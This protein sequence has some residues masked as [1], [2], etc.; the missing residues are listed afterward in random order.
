VIRKPCVAG[1]FYPSDREA[2]EGEVSSYVRSEEE[3]IPALGL[4]SPHAGYMYSGGVAGVTF[5]SVEL[6]ERFI[7]LCPNH[8]G[9]GENLS[10][11]T[12][13]AWETPLGSTPIDSEIAGE[14]L[15]GYHRLK[16]DPSAHA[17]EHSLEVQL[18]FLQ[19]LKGPEEFSF[20]PLCVGERRYEILEEVGEV[21]GRI[22]KERG[23]E[24]FIVVSSDMNHFESQDVS[25]RKDRLALERLEELD[26]RGLF[27][28]VNRNKISMCGVL[29]AVIA[30][31]AFS[32]AGGS[33]GRLI[34]YT[35]SAEMSGDRTNV[36]GYAGMVFV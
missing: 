8:T 1:S 15:E 21:L 26:Y 20:I 5:S 14:L 33:R 34:R 10:I 25:E 22:L 30:L 12:K 17:H 9:Y 35:T 24:I 18:P 36:V 11:M 27:D 7:I 19:Y 3:K 31:K 32:L 28:T 6:P 16:D 23:R 29:P 13:G 4:V 2:L